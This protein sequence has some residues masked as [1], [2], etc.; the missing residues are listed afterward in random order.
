MTL[1]SPPASRGGPPPEDLDR[2]LG[3]LFRARMPHPWPPAPATPLHRTPR[4]PLLRSRLALA[5]SVA[6]LATG[7]LF[8]A[9]A[10]PGRPS[11]S[12]PAL[13]VTHPSAD[14]GYDTGRPVPTPP[15]AGKLK[16]DESLIQEPNGTTI[17]VDVRDWPTPPK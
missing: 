13:P 16:I 8:L 1:L 10:F 5:A 15:D 2:R 7:L 6:L 14:R 12:G 3:A 17:R 9:G 4:W 11:A